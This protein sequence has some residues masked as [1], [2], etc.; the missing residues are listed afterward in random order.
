MPLVVYK[1]IAKHVGLYES[2]ADKAEVLAEA[3]RV[4]GIELTEEKLAMLKDTLQ[5]AMKLA[6]SKNKKLLTSD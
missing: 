6:E 1:K 3:S 5:F 4:L 2:K